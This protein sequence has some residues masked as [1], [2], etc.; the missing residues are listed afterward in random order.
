[1]LIDIDLLDRVSQDIPCY[2]FNTQSFCKNIERIRALLGNTIK[3]KYSVKANP[4][5][6]QTAL[7]H[8][9]GLEICSLGELFLAVSGGV[10]PE[11]ILYGGVCKEKGDIV[12]ALKEGVRK[13]SVESLYQLKQIDA[14]ASECAVD[15]EVLLRISAGNQFGMDMQELREC[16]A[17]HSMGHIR[18]KGLHYYPG[19]MRMTDEEIQKDYEQFSVILDGLRSFK[20]DEIEYG[21]GIGIDYYGNPMQWRLAEHIADPLKAMSKQHTVILELG[22]LVAADAGLYIARVVEIRKNGNRLFVIIN[23]GRH[24]FTYHGGIMTL[25]KRVPRLS[26]IQRRA[27]S[28]KIKATI[29]GSLCNP[30]DILAND[31]E[32]PAV[33]EGDYIIFHN[34]G[35][36]CNTEGTALF[37]SRDL[38][39]ILFTDGEGVQVW[40][41]RNIFE[42]LKNIYYQEEKCNERKIL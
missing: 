28:A 6:I 4:F 20:I 36:Y 26:V 37:L 40:R 29:V 3:L 10:R 30:G 12:V 31:I 5:F 39:A 23:G 33:R 42:W 8:M 2:C 41:R 27:S 22:R 7:E 38:P 21:C 17:V 1:M 16:F 19:P 25:G 9:D 35:A 11:E 24:H 13:F 14:A 15:V 18:I 32:I 34:A